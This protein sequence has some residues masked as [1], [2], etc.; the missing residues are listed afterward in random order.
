MTDTELLDALQELNDKAEYTGRC[1][2]RI[3]A[4]RGWR[5]HESS[6]TY[7]DLGNTFISVRD[8]IEQFLKDTNSDNTKTH[9][10]D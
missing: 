1:I 3:S 5:L 2:L 6:S 4:R 9:D 10:T 8:A 7:E